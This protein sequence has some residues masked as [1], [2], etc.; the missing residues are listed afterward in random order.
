MVDDYD[1]DV[2][3]YDGI[4]VEKIASEELFSFAVKV[5][6][7]WQD[8][9]MAG[10]GAAGAHGEHRNQGPS[11]DEF[12]N[13]GDAV[14]DVTVDPQGEG[15]LEYIVGGDVIQLAVAEF[16]RRPGA[17]PPPFDP[18]SRW[19]REVGLE[20]EDGQS[21]E[22]M[23]DTIRFAIG[24]RGLHGF[25]PARAAAR[26]YDSGALADRVHDRFER[27]LESSDVS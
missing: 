13:T 2:D 9:L 15:A 6:N 5:K 10:R 14:N 3:T 11:P 19:A 4:D 18:I 25:A 7:Q 21:W 22:N 24:A 1:V 26:E 27:E 12:H 8:N 20:P 16:G 23:V 17:P